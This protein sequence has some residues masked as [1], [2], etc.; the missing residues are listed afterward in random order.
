MDT[1]KVFFFVCDI[2]AYPF[3]TSVQL[4]I[5]HLS[6]VTLL[7]Q[8]ETLTVFGTAAVPPALTPLSTLNGPDIPKAIITT[9]L[10]ECV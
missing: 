9:V 2:L 7:Q 5:F 4:C 10:H 1:C 3:I 8:T 6:P